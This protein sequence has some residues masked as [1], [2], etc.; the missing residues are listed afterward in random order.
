MYFQNAIC[1][2]QRYY[3]VAKK[4]DVNNCAKI[5]D[6]FRTRKAPLIVFFAHFKHLEQFRTAL[7][8]KICSLNKLQTNKRHA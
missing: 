8:K 5:Y 4:K 7:S 2:Q 3:F 1:K 6:N